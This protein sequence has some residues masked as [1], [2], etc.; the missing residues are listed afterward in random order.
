MKHWLSIGS[1]FAVSLASFGCVAE[2]GQTAADDPMGEMSAE[3]M[4][5]P[6]FDRAFQTVK[7]IDYL[8]FQ[9]KV[10]GC[11]A[12][13]LYMSMELAAKGMESNSVFAF[14][15][16]GYP[17]VVGPIHWRYHVAPLLEVGPDAAHLK[18]M[19][20]DPALSSTPITEMDWVAKMSRPWNDPVSSPN[21]LIVPG[22][23]YAPAE[24]RA[25]VTYRNKDVPD[26]AH[27]PPFRASDVQSACGVIYNYIAI[28]PGTTPQIVQSK[29]TKLV[30][31]SV[32]L[33][34]ALDKLNKLSKDR[35][36]SAAQCQT[37]R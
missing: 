13:A 35:T 16:V 28:E 3:W 36:F 4:K 20:I 19:V 6:V 5:Q 23:D 37:G 7:A 24:A 32:L 25:E 18:P 15:R 11:Y 29:Q 27:L 30:T 34:S 31:R 8:P 21:M 33:V 22:S 10:D 9:Y 12:R 1:L 26:F 2:S 14:A 17:L